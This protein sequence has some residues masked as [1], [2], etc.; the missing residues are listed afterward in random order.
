MPEGTKMKG[1]TFET[2]ILARSSPKAQ[3]EGCPKSYLPKR[4]NSL[5]EQVLMA[6]EEYDKMAPLMFYPFQTDNDLK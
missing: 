2:C 3:V 1:T 4:I 6:R 5:S